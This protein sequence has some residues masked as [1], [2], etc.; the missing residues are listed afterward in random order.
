VVCGSLVSYRTKGL[1]REKEDTSGGT[2]VM[3]RE[4]VMLSMMSDLEESTLDGLAMEFKIPEAKQAILP[5]YLFSF[6]PAVNKQ[7][8]MLLKP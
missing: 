6:Y 8:Q 2:R 5:R 3:N 1:G 4:L 7:E